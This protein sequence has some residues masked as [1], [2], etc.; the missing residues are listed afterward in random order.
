MIRVFVG[1]QH[2]LLFDRLQPSAYVLPSNR[3]N[4]AIDDKPTTRARSGHVTSRF[5]TPASVIQR[6]SGDCDRCDGPV[7]VYYQHCRAVPTTDMTYSRALDYFFC[8]T[9]TVSLVT[10]CSQSDVCLVGDFAQ[11][12]GK[13]CKTSDSNALSLTTKAVLVVTINIFKQ[14]ESF[15]ITKLNLFFNGTS[16]FESPTTAEIKKTRLLHQERY[17]TSQQ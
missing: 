8:V 4:R 17:T 12:A 7:V 3:K 13:P 10:L 5:V 1:E 2:R 11:G 6:D 14:K 9:M 16:N 15:K